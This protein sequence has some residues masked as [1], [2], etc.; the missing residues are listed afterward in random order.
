MDCKY[1]FLSSNAL[2]NVLFCNDCEQLLIGIGTLIIKFNNEQSRV[3]CKALQKA[4]QQVN[5]MD[6]ETD[7]KIFLKTP[8]SNIMIALN[9]NELTLAIELI[10]F[11]LLKQ[12]INSL[13]LCN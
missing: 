12:E 2:G 4:Q 11:A 6:Y 7:E 1:E 5:N 3:F 13:I 10:E 9:E 8:V